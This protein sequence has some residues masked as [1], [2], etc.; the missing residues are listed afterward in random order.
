MLPTNAVANEDG[1]LEECMFSE[2]THALTL[3]VTDLSG[4]S[5][6][7]SI[8]LSV[9]GTNTNPDCSIVSPENGDVFLVGDSMAFPATADA[10]VAIDDLQVMWKSDKDGDLGEGIINSSGDVQLSTSS[11]SANEHII[12]FLVQDELES[13]LPCSIVI[14]VE[15]EGTAPHHSCFTRWRYR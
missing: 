10:E 6:E 7:R 4:K 12:Q 15:E 1:L 3:A 13:S 5:T 8:S 14:T 11:L 9:G 2:G